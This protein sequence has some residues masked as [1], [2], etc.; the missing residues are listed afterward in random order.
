MCKVTNDISKEHIIIWRMQNTNF[1]QH[2][3]LVER[4]NLSSERYQVADGSRRQCWLD[5]KLVQ[6]IARIL[7][8]PDEI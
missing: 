5:A 2:T 1:W 3:H 6:V 8:I 7:P 4:V